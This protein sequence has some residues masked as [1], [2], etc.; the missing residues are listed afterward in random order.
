MARKTQIS[1]DVILEAAFHMLLRD[2]YAVINITSLAKEIGC[3]TQPIAW[4]FGNME[5]LRD[6][7][8]EYCLIFLKD[9]FVVEREDVSG[10]LEGIALQ[11]VELAFDYPN[12]YK[13]LYM[14]EQDGKKMA[15]L[16]QSHR[17]ENQNKVVQML[18]KEYGISSDTATKYLLN[19][20]LYVHGI[21]SFAV[22]KVSFP[23]KEVIMEMIHE[24]SEAF[25][26]HLKEE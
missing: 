16:A 22:T 24:A 17:A 15:M 6:A 7:L 11:Y 10:I 9:R 20:Q 23:S 25:L 1:K 26:K 18:K 21:A 14:S 13:Y 4:H 5:G 3:S 19:L 2:G 12:L 8:L